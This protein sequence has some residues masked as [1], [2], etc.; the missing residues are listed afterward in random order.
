[1]RARILPGIAASIVLAI[2]S[3]GCAPLPILAALGQG[4]RLLTND[5]QAFR[6]DTNRRLD[7]QTPLLDRD[8]QAGVGGIGAIL[9]V[10][11]LQ[12]MRVGHRRTSDVKKEVRAMGPSNGSTI[13]PF[14]PPGAA[15]PG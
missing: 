7:A 1:M 6:A 11:L 14:K 9:L 10:Y 5:F 3:T 15:A 12:Q 4:A 2:V 8:A 13:P